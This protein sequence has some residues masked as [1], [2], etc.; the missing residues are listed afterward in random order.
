M[1][2]ASPAWRQPAVL[3]TCGM[4]L[5]IA[6]ALMTGGAALALLWTL[7]RRDA[8]PVA[9]ASDIAIYKDQLAELE[10]DRDRGLIGDPEAEAARIEI[11]RRLIAADAAR[12]RETA[13]NPSLARR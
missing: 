12:R 3:W 4:V 9:R 2:Y 7:A 5:W 13:A 1:A 10:R 8:A 6:I 11:S